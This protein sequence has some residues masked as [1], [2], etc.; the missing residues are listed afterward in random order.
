[1]EAARGV[2]RYYDRN[3]RRFLALG[4]SGPALAIH[5]PL[6]PEGVTSPAAAAAHVNEVVAAMA[7]RALG[8]PPV[9]IR[10]LGCGVGG[11]LLHLA[12]RWPG[13]RALGLT[14]SMAQVAL[15]Q[16][17]VTRRGLSGRVD[18]R[19][20]DYLAPPP[21]CADLV[22]AIESHVH[23]PS[24]EAFLRAAAAQ[25]VPGGVLVVVDDM[26]ARPETELDAAGRVRVS[27]FRRGWRLGHV[28]TV[29]ALS[30]GAAS[31]G[32][33]SVECRDL[34]PLL[35]LERLRDRALR[36]V[37]PIA[38]GLGLG[39][40]PLWGNMIGGNALTEAYRAGDMRYVALALGRPA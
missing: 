22:L 36:L 17:E 15:G 34:T 28:P 8:R 20:A 26:L 23:A 18:L 32:L 31:L 40:W 6:W 38:D 39:R 7:E 37:A 35:R 29:E 12:C 30:D 19:R 25:I 21:G 24:A 16:G 2:A 3:T 13:A 4:Q 5:R 14:L 11:S 1:M 27:A 10:D 9:T 33:V